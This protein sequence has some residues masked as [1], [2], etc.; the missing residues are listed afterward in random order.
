MKVCGRRY[1]SYPSVKAEKPKFQ[2]GQAP[3]Q[4][5]SPVTQLWPLRCEPTSAEWSFFGQ[6]FALL[7]KHM[8]SDAGPFVPALC[9][10]FCL[11]PPCEG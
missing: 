10:P 4:L 9:P 5:G 3:L 7:I 1:T 2:F 6:V 8:E 11:E